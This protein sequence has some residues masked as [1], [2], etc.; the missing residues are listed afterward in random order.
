MTT[1]H[2]DA[3]QYELT[4]DGRALDTQSSWS[5]KY[6]DGST[7]DWLQQ[8]AAERERN[9]VLQSQAGMRGILLPMLEAFRMWF[10]VIA[11]GIGIGL[12]GAWLDI[13]VKW[14]AFSFYFYCAGVEHPGL[15][16]YARDVAPMD[17]S[18]TRLHAV[19]V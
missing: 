5:A 16:T 10:V 9:Q 18:I 1:N 6:P 11:T 13:L 19:E 2:Y 14:C 12:I 4:E 3:E 8:D 7:I 17:F 15:G